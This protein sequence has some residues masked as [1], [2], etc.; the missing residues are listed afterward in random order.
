MQ[1]WSRVANL[2]RRDSLHREIDE[3]L[4]AHIEE[5]I[6]EG[7]DPEEVRKT[8]GS[9]LRYRELSHDVRLVTWI[10]ALRAD[11]IFGWRQLVKRPATSI[12]AI[13]SLAL[14]IGSCAS[15]F[16]LVDALLL[17]PLPITHSDRLYAMVLHGIG[18]DGSVRDSDWGEYPQFLLMRAA[19][20]SDAELIAVSAVDRVDLTFGSDAEMERAH[21]QFVSG[22]MFSAFGL[23]PALG[24]LLTQADDL[25]PKAS[26]YAVISYHYW[27]QRFG[28]DPKIIGRRFQLAND[29]YEIVGVAPKEFTGTDTG[30][31]PTFSSRTPCMKAPRMTT[32]AGSERSYNSS[33]MAA[34]NAC[35]SACKRSGKAFKQSE[36][37]GSQA[38][39]QIGSEDTC[40]NRWSYNQRAPGSRTCRTV[41]ALRYTR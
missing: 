10:D 30:T 25:K 27:S 23:Q 41:I 32:G 4:N 12:A 36:P 14:A 26:P 21:R 38:G 15:V 29:L 13:L 6:E 28:R 5:A 35:G 31:S 11:L 33:L 16:R 9:L 40:S 20:K 19:A 34:K 37:K 3:E 24:R 2:F 8:F 22:W 1:I 17:R 7:R 39:R 18:P